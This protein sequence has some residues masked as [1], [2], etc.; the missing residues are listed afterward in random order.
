[1]SPFSIYH[2]CNKA[3]EQ[4]QPYWTD[5]II[6]SANPDMIFLLGASL[7]RRRSESIFQCT[8]PSSQHVGD[9]FFLV[10]IG[11][12]GNKTFLEWQDKIEANTRHMGPASVWVLSTNR[13]HDWLKKGAFLCRTGVAK[14]GSFTR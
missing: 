12:L 4:L 3:I 10:L 1:M 8:S 11:E 6:Q 9:F 5:A 13:F 7:H 14:S 2:F